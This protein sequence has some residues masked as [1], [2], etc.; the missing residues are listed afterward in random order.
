MDEVTDVDRAA[1]S[2]YGVAV[3][4]ETN[5]GTLWAQAP[6]DNAHVTWK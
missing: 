1:V 4:L 5:V 6:G 3:G 2:R